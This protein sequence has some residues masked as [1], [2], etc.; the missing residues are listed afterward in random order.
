MPSSMP[1][2]RKVMLNPG[3]FW[4]KVLKVRGAPV[5]LVSSMASIPG[6]RAAGGSASSGR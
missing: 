6:R 2:S 1:R 4:S 5:T 3:T